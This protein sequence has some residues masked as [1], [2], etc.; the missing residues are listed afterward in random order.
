MTESRVFSHPARPSSVNQYFIIPPLIYYTQFCWKIFERLGARA[1]NKQ[2]TF[3]GPDGF[4]WTS[5]HQPVRLYTRQI[6]KAFSIG[7]HQWGRTVVEHC[8]LI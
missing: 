6:A 2:M 4:F 8:L 3:I 1:L 7:L 5:W